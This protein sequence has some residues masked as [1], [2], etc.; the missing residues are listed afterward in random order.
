MIETASDARR[1]VSACLYAPEGARSFGPVRARLVWGDGYA[2]AANREILPIAMIE[3]RAAGD[4]LD[5]IAATP[6]LA[7]LYI[8]PADLSLV[9]GLAPGFD[10]QEPLMLQLI[11]R[12][13]VACRRNGIAAGI[14]CG[15]PAYARRRALEGFD[16]ITIGSDARYI[17]ACAKAATACFRQAT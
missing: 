16:L 15:D 7:G 3:T 9:H 13:R 5:E 12:V 8:G 1:L 14:H 11:E 10:R 4:N 6:G 17:E 2:A